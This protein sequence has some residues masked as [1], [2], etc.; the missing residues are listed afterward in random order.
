MTQPNLNQGPTAGTS[1]QAGPS[2]TKNTTPAGIS[3][4]EAPTA[5]NT[6]SK[7][8]PLNV[9]ELEDSD[10]GQY[11]DTTEDDSSEYDPDED[12]DDPVVAEYDVFIPPQPED[13]ELWLL[14]F[15]G[16]DKSQHLKGDNAPTGF[17]WKEESKYFEVDVPINIHSKTYDKR[18]GI[19][20]GEALKKTKA[21]GQESYGVAQGFQRVMPK[22]KKKKKRSGADAEDDDEEEEE[23]AAEEDE[24]SAMPRKK[25][26]GPPVIDDET[27]DQF[28]ANFADANEK[29]HVLNTQTWGGGMIS[30]EDFKPNYMVG[31]FRGK[32]CH[33][34]P[35]TGIAQLQPEIHHIDATDHLKT[36]SEAKEEDLEDP[37]E[38]LPMFKKATDELSDAELLKGNANEPW[39]HLQWIPS[40]SPA[41]QEHKQKR[42]YHPDPAN[43]PRVQF[44]SHEDYKQRILPKVVG[45]N[46]KGKVP[47]YR[48]KKPVASRLT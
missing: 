31:V 2:G 24:G 25:A 29:G 39:T 36:I 15:L 47:P 9:W 37:K 8:T 32:E 18:K 19:E 1:S 22:P 23:E 35:L 14:Q 4:G 17:R 21:L 5:S 48:K 28:M 6:A 11:G 44:E 34:T 27:V 12:E 13:R 45:G 40:D 20:F 26:Q 38:V 33:L 42:L 43:A 41:A 46:D 16:R 7:S 30:Q 10:D 3:D